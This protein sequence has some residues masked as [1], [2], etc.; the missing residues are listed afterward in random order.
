M[1]HDEI[2]TIAFMVIAIPVGIGIFQLL[3]NFTLPKISPIQKI[4]YLQA[5]VILILITIPIGLFN[6]VRQIIYYW[7]ST[8]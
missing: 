8:L 5:V 6:L 3:W 1:N 2:A 4:T 7:S